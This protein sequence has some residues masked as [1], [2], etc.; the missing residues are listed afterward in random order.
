MLGADYPFLDV[1]WTMLV[2]FAWVI[3]FWLLITVFGD[4][5]RR[6]D[7]SGFAKAMWMIFVIV[8]PYLGV[9]VYLIA[10]SKGMA[11]RNMQQAQAA[12][13][14]FDDYVKNVAAES[15]PAGEIERAKQ[16]LDSGAISQTEFDSLKAKALA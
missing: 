15:G 5:F 14:Q 4:L 9:F 3:W 11:E 8:L 13:S 2:F 6:H 10:E 12:Q 1:L 16:L 7:I